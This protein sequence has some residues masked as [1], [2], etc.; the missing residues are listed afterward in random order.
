M[1]VPERVTFGPFELDIAGKKLEKGGVRVK[2]SGQPLDILVL[3]LKSPDE[4]VTRE[5][6]R[7]QLWGEDTFVDFEQGLNTAINKLR[8]TLGDSADRPRYIETIPRQGYRLIAPVAEAAAH[9][10]GRH[11]QPP[12]GSGRKR[13]PWFAAIAG[14]AALV[15]LAAGYWMGART[16]PSPTANLIQFKVEPPPGYWLEPA[17]T[18][19]GFDISP[20]GRSL[21]FT[22]RG[23]DGQFHAWRRDLSRTALHPIST[24]DAAHTVFW[25][26]DSK[27]LFFALGG[28]LRLADAVGGPFQVLG[29]ERGRAVYATVIA[30]ERVLVMGNRPSS[31]LVPTVGGDAQP[32]PAAYPW[33]EPLP[34]SE[35]ILYLAFGDRSHNSVVRAARVGEEPESG[36]EIVQTNSRTLYAP[37]GPGSDQGHL[38]YVH[39][40]SL[41]A[42]PFDAKSLRVTGQAVPLAAGIEH[43]ATSGAADFS[44]STNGVLVYQPHI[45]R[46]QMTWVDRA[47][48]PVG[49]V[50]PANQGIYYLRLSPDSTKIVAE[51]YS[52][53]DGYSRVWIFD[54]ATGNGRPITEELAGGSVWSPD[55]SRLVYSGLI[56]TQLPRLFV[57]SVTEEGYGKPLLAGV[58]PEQVQVPNGLVFRRTLHRLSEPASGRSVDGG[59]GGQALA[60]AAVGFSRLGE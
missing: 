6:L 46:A 55:S 4:V 54:S 32:L 21:V 26:P 58:H 3:L 41:M 9:A 49:T 2:L 18:R 40:G 5:E 14:L 8:Q 36:A 22:A 24:A 48:R 45:G 47:G 50:G 17:G 19:Q 44:V 52:V 23:R 29:Q 13:P 59:S 51:L 60:D 31:Y 27:K 38:L 16:V 35:Y 43:F 57:R 1:P 33:P 42:H 56:V 39:A 7:Q 25:G 10:P 20:D 30:P 11:P 15:V 12:G 37:S 28:S 34:A 53:E